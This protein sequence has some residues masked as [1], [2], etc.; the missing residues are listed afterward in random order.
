MRGQAAAWKGPMEGR[1]GVQHRLEQTEDRCGRDG[2]YSNVNL[3]LAGACHRL[4]AITCTGK[5]LPRTNL[6][7]VRDNNVNLW[8]AGARRRRRLF[9]I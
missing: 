1:R 3:S 7:M 4:I 6:G 5:P 8:L 2:H 9:L